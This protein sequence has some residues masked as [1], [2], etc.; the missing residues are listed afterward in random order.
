MRTLLL[1]GTGFWLFV[2]V[3]I[4]ICLTTSLVVIIPERIAVLHIDVVRIVI[5]SRYVRFRA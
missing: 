1:L 4:S 5:L 3:T 2:A